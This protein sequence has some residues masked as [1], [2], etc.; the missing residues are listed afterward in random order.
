MKLARRRNERVESTPMR[1]IVCESGGAQ[2]EP[3]NDGIRERD[4]RARIILYIFR[5]FTLFSTKIN[6]GRWYTFTSGA[7]RRLCCYENLKLMRLLLHL[8]HTHSRDHSLS[9]ESRDVHHNIVCLFT[10]W[11]RV[12]K[13][14]IYHYLLQ[15]SSFGGKFVLLS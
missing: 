15:Y 2:D 1:I 8:F 4:V 13:I 9:L 11:T 14:A 6:G 3:P 7:A 12:S 5:C 10:N